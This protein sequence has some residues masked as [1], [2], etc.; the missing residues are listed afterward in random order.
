MDATTNNNS[1]DANAA[2]AAGT[3]SQSNLEAAPSNNVSPNDDANDNIEAA[4]DD[5]AALGDVAAL[6]RDEHHEGDPNFP[7]GKTCPITF[8]PPAQGVRFT[9]P[10]DNGFISDQVFEY[11]ALFRMIFHP[12]GASSRSQKY[13]RH[14]LTSAKVLRHQGLSYFEMVTADEQRVIAAER[15]NRNL[16]AHDIHPLTHEDYIM[17]QNIQQSAIER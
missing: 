17:M 9:V 3:E 11:S 15:A 10:D 6:E 1:S 13:V 7:S 8:H 12:F 2:A 14:P 16:P 4:L 5:V